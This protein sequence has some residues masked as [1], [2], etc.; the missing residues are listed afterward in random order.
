MTDNQTKAPFASPAWVD[1]ARE[2]LEEL[3]AQHGEDGQ[4][5]SICEAFVEAPAEIADADGCAA[6]HFYIDGKNV[7]VGTGR[8][9]E[10]DIQIQATWETSLPGARLVYTPE[11]L[12]EWEKNPPERPVDPNQKV[13]GDMTNLP[14]YLMELH[15]RMAVVTE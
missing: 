1:I 8:I 14:T 11:L 6:W 13:E 5:L 10:A 7:R 15:N 3:V 12:A 4:T 9:A 2:V